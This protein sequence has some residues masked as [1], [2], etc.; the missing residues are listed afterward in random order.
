MM[1][2]K[3]DEKKA[4]EITDDGKVVDLESAITFP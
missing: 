2:K 1:S 4:Q 3:V